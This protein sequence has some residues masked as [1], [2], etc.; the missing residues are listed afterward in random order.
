MNVEHIIKKIDW[1][2]GVTMD[3]GQKGE[4]PSK[5]QQ[6]KE[7]REQ[8]YNLLYSACVDY[9][10]RD[11]V[12]AHHG[13]DQIETFLMRLYRGS[14]VSG[15]ACMR[16]VQE[17]EDGTRRIRP[18]L[19]VSKQRLIAT[20]KERSVPYVI[21]PSNSDLQYD[22]NRVR[23]GVSLLQ[24]RENID[25][26]CFLSAV[27]F[28]QEIRDQL[29]EEATNAVHKCCEYNQDLGICRINTS[30]LSTYPEMIV[31]HVL[32]MVCSNISGV[33]LPSE[34]AIQRV[35]KI[36][37]KEGRIEKSVQIAGCVVTELKLGSTVYA[38]KKKSDQW[39]C[40]CIDRNQLPQRAVDM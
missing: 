12:I 9:K 1:V 28:F 39:V 4:S 36:L 3:Y 15:L 5:T 11:V 14:G 33:M 13:D 37:C 38:K 16:S 18:L 26:G 22:R 6:E 32:R 8:R 29:T 17:M 34:K 2:D 19:E 40:V 7:G 25:V 24:E 23:Y 35:T 30:V 27:R 21:D 10:T 31:A 20:C